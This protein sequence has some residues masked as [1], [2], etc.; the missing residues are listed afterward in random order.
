MR[1][2]FVVSHQQRKVFSV[3]FFPNS[4][5]FWTHKISLRSKALSDEN[6]WDGYK[7]CETHRKS[8]RIGRLLH[9]KGNTFS[10][11]VSGTE[12]LGSPS[13]LRT[14]KHDPSRYHQHCPSW[15]GGSAGTFS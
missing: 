4:I 11:G 12:G 9:G 6:P 10:L 14:S 8:V 3:K 13:F 15:H 5:N 1:S 2:I 7:N